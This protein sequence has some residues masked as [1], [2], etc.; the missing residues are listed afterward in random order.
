M[1]QEQLSARLKDV[2]QWTRI[3]YIVL[4]ALAYSAA[5][6]LLKIVVVVQIGTSLVTGGPNVKLSQ[7]A[8]VLTHY[9][10]QLA[11]FLTY[12]SEDSPFPSGEW[13]DSAWP[14]APVDQVA[15]AAA[16]ERSAPQPP[17]KSDVPVEVKD[18]PDSATNDKADSP[19]AKKPRRSAAKKANSEIVKPADSGADEEAGK[20]SEPTP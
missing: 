5:N 11:R 18:K 15:T 14:V 13:P 6:F 8:G 16:G 4:F 1:E 12:N 17:V 9:L 7:F 20:G 10:F 2:S 3:L 19:A